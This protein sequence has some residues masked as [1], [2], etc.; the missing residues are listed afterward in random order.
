MAETLSQGHAQHIPLKPPLSNHGEPLVYNLRRPR[1]LCQE[2]QS[3]GWDS[4]EVGGLAHEQVPGRRDL[5]SVILEGSHG[6][7]R[8]LEGPAGRYPPGEV[9][10]TAQIRG[11][12]S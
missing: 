12:A 3:Q 2:F 1:I 8:S 9:A 5:A 7:S 10:M 6:E 4:G 11:S